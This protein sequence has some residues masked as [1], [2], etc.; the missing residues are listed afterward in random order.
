MLIN[1]SN[2]LFN[3]GGKK[4]YK[5]NHAK[6]Y[7]EFQILRA[8][9]A[10]ILREGCIN[11]P[12]PP[13]YLSKNISKGVFLTFNNKIKIFINYGIVIE[14]SWKLYVQFKHIFFVKIFEV[15]LDYENF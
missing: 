15:N 7:N 8:S 2:F 5:I 12:P 3:L 11:H 9:C 13:P 10:I 6:F 1:F 4:T 14:V